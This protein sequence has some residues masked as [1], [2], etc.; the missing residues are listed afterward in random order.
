MVSSILPKNE[1]N[2]LRIVSW[3][4]KSLWNV[5]FSFWR[6]LVSVRIFSRVLIE[7]QYT[8]PI[9]DRI[10]LFLKRGMFNFSSESMLVATGKMQS[11]ERNTIW[12]WGKVIYSKYNLPETNSFLSAQMT[13]QSSFFLVFTASL[14]Y[15]TWDVYLWIWG[16]KVHTMSCAKGWNEL[17][18]SPC[19]WLALHNGEFLQNSVWWI[20]VSKVRISQRPWQ[21][22]LYSPRLIL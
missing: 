8:Y 14:V 11:F 13:V 1:R 22:L 12:I 9:P 19:I 3:V 20:S 6:A 15:S 2:A 7:S 18:K 16:R 10:Q 5:L 21:L 4:H 17:R